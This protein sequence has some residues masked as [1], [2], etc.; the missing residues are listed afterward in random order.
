MERGE[1]TA[2]VLGFAEGNTPFALP[3][4]PARGEANQEVFSL[5][6][7]GFC[8]Y[9]TGAVIAPASGPSRRPGGSHPSRLPHRHD[10]G[11]SD[12]RVDRRRR[13]STSSLARPALVAARG[14]V[15]SPA[16]GRVE[17]KHR[18]R[19]LRRDAVPCRDVPVGWWP[20][21]WACRSGSAGGAAVPGVACV[22]SRWRFVA[23]VGHCVGLR[24]ALTIAGWYPKVRLSTGFPSPFVDPDEARCHPGTVRGRNPK[25]RETQADG[26]TV[27]VTTTL[28]VARARRVSQPVP[29]GAR[30]GSVPVQESTS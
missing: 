27:S 23:G 5:Q 6:I 28:P 20:A 13:P 17:R 21:G 15:H 30:L 10:G 22:A 25:A 16:R 9:S 29:Q 18:E 11:L 19:L 7:G 1:A 26:A 24:A 14:A 12:R 3:L 8:P 4:S 2:T